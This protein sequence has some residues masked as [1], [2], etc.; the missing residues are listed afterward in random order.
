MQQQ[1]GGEM[2][3]ESLQDVVRQKL[4]KSADCLSCSRNTNGSVWNC[5]NS[6][7]VFLRISFKSFAE[8]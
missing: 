4:L 3:V 1:F 7:A 2:N 6:G 8:I 5:M